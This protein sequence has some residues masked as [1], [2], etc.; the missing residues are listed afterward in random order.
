MRHPIIHRISRAAFAFALVGA[1]VAVPSAAR[2]D[3][4]ITLDG[5]PGTSLLA[6][7]PA[8]NAID[9]TSFSFS[10]SGAAGG[11]ASAPDLVVTRRVDKASGPILA[12]MTSGTRFKTAQVFLV[13]RSSAGASST[14]YRV[15]L[16]DVGIVALKHTAGDSDTAAQEQLTLDFSRAEVEVF[17]VDARGTTV[18]AGRTVV[19]GKRP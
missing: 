14:V 3:V 17:T 6:K 12:A 19:S 13:A 9:A 18:S 5:V 4:L 16:S 2:A 1:C 7:G 11:R 8:P 10:F 15:S